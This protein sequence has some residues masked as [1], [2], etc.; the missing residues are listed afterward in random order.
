MTKKVLISPAKIKVCPKGLHKSLT[1][2]LSPLA[3]NAI[4]PKYLR[5]YICRE[6]FTYVVSA[7]QIHLFM[8]NKPKFKKV[9]SNVNKVLTRNYE[10]LD[11]WSIRKKQ[12]QTNPILEAK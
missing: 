6:T 5:L 11:T 7:L 9:K 1:P 8:Q 12:S 4:V 3:P 10:Q 2:R